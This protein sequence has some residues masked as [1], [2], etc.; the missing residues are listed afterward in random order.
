MTDD[1]RARLTRITGPVI[2]FGCFVGTWYLAHYVL[3]SENRRFLVPPPHAVVQEAFLTGS[4]DGGTATLATSAGGGLSDQLEAL[5]LSAQ[6][7]LLGLS[8]AIVI[9]IALATL[10]SQAKWVEQAIYPYLVALQAIPILAFVPRI[11]V[12][13][14]FEFRS[15][16]LVCVI[17]ALFP[18]VANTLFGLLSVDRSHR[19]LMT[20]HGASRLRQLRTLQ[21]PAAMPAI[22]TGLQISA[23]LAVIGA[24]V[25]DFFFRQG[26]PGIGQ[27]IDR[28]RASLAYEQMYGSV[29]LA[30]VLGIVVFWFFGWLGRR[31]VGAWYEPAAR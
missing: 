6:V 31:V 19:E 10:M 9:G 21:F 4:V 8:I 28:Y 18:I 23:G 24:I 3:M 7:A 11:G 14:G 13:W 2:V 29:I 20:L 30:A 1:R 12:L 25:G 15:R 26:Q 27:L 5:W 22:F 17:I 16:V